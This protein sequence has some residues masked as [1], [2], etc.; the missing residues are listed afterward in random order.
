MDNPG[1]IP[2]DTAQDTDYTALFNKES[3]EGFYT[4]FP[5]SMFRN[6]TRG[7]VLLVN[8]LNKV[9]NQSSLFTKIAKNI[10]NE[11]YPPS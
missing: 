4:G 2:E 6:W 5:G 11:T 1:K 10:L 8:A 7:F 9:T 3:G